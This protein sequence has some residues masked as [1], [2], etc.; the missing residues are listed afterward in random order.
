VWDTAGQERF[1]SITRAYYR[2]SRGLLVVY[3]ITVRS[4]WENAKYWVEEVRR[5]LADDVDMM[6][7]ILGTAVLTLAF[8]V[9]Q[10]TNIATF[11]CG[12]DSWRKERPGASQASV[13][14]G[15]PRTGPEVGR[16]RLG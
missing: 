15:G 2:G 16:R 5:T 1:R 12:F 10:L 9:R 14:G 3:D 6:P 11:V 13:A 8:C 7:F 4:S